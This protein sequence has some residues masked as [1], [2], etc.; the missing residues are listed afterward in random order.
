MTH[1][2]GDSELFEGG[3]PRTGI[4]LLHGSATDPDR[5]ISRERAGLGLHRGG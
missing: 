4:V 5:T 2:I 1:P 3:L